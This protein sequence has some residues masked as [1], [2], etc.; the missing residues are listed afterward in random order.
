MA[1]SVL[2]EFQSHIKARTTVQIINFMIRGNEG[3]QG[4]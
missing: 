4:G 1:C 3:D 2:R